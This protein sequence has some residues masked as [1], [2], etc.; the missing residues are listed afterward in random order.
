MASQIS[1]KWLL[2][3]DSKQISLFQ[4]YKQNSDGNT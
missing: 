1:E 4:Q 3:V 2:F